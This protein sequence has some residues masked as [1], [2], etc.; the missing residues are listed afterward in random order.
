MSRTRRNIP[1]KR[2]FRRPRTTN[3]IKQNKQLEVD[4]RIDEFPCNI[5]KRNRIH[6]F[7]PTAYDD[8]RI[9]WL[10]KNRHH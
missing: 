6:R 4:I 5:D 2:W 7:I 8:L 10:L 3:E 9:S 1:H